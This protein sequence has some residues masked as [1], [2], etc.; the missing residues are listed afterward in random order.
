MTALRPTRRQS[1]GEALAEGLL[2]P[3]PP[4]F[5]SISGRPSSDGM[6]TP[7]DG[8]IGTGRLIPMVEP[9]LGEVLAVVLGEDFV[10]EP[11]ELLALPP[12]PSVAA[13][14]EVEASVAPEDVGF[15]APVCVADPEA[16][17]PFWPC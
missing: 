1:D 4:R 13:G 10:E 5:T 15:A 17:P 8:R 11:A 16:P 9:A 6:V 7:I 12:L 3:S 14:A 2:P